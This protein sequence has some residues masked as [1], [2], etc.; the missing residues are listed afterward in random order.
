MAI[1]CSHSRHRQAV[2]PAEV[3]NLMEKRK[4]TC[5]WELVVSD[6]SMS[7]WHEE[8]GIRVYIF[9]GVEEHAGPFI[10]GMTLFIL[11]RR[12]IGHTELADVTSLGK[13]L[14]TLREFFCNRQLVKA[15]PETDK[16][17]EAF[18]RIRSFV[19]GTVRP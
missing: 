8:D 12:I 19:R 6:G 5:I 4:G 9:D 16:A 3:V 13:S 10:S 18:E 17:Q 2:L 7:V 11:L 15:G 14:R 1:H